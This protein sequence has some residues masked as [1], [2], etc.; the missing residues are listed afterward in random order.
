M[1]SVKILFASD[2]HGSD[3]V[4][5]KLLD[6]TITWKAHALIIG[7][8]VSGK[9]MTPIL[10]KSPHSYEA[11][12]QGN[13]LNLE[14]EIEVEKLEKH[15]SSSGSYPIRLTVDEYDKMQSDPSHKDQRFLV[16]MKLRLKRWIT[17]AQKKLQPHGTRF[18]LMCGND[19][20][21]ELD[22]VISSS[23]FAENP[24]RTILTLSDRHEIIGESGTNVT[25]FNCPRDMDENIL[26]SRIE[27]KVKN[28]KD[29]SKAI[30]VLHAPPFNSQLDLALKLDHN[31][32]PIMVGGNAVEEPVGSKAV[33]NMIEQYQPLLSL[34]GHIH[35]KPGFRSIGRTKCVNAGSEYDRG[36]MKAFFLTIID[37]E[38]RGHQPLSY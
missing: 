10:Q 8:D 15:I 3:L 12:F 32:K 16:E 9:T 13:R 27:A 35:E 14:S 26:Q 29:L 38:V 11:N 17:D 24:E 34:H 30:F 1:N 33:R 31:L 6:A 20:R 2:L 37:N 25:P 18:I 5:E 19:D 7:G 4:F 28:I 21:W 23:N 22:D 36:I